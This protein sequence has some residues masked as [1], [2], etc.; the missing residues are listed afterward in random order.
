MLHAVECIQCA[1][2]I[3]DL[4]RY[5]YFLSIFQR[6]FGLFDYDASNRQYVFFIIIT[7][8]NTTV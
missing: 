7:L 2:H 5:I 8:I 1:L 3:I 4:F 6:C